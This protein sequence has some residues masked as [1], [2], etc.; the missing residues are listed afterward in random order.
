METTGLYIHVPFCSGKCFYC[1]FYSIPAQPV[2]IDDYLQ[3]LSREARILRERFF[4]D[5]RP[6]VETIYIGGGTPTSLDPDQLAILGRIIA[7][8]FE[9]TSECEFTSEAN[10]ESVTGEKIRVLRAAGVNRISLGV[11]TFDDS[12]LK[13]IGRR[14]TSR[15]AMAAVELASGA[16]VENISLDLIYALPGQTAEQFNRDLAKATGLPIRH[17]SC[18][19][20]TY[21]PGTTL[22]P[23]RPRELTLEQE[24]QQVDLFLTTHRTLT[25]KDFEHYEISNYAR[26][27][28]PCRHN[29]RYWKNLEY[30]GLGPS[31]AGL[32]NRRRYKNSTD[33]KTYCQRLLEQNELPVGG[34][35]T[36]SDLEFAGETAMLALRT[37]A[38]IDRNEFFR[39]T[40][41]EPFELYRAT[42]EK[43]KNSGLLETTEDRIFLNLRGF[44]LSNEVLAE[45]LK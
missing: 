14:H 6:R 36:L 21:E 10:P 43:F 9:R 5:R 23:S 40:G 35:E 28:F 32:L 33:L 38:G 31:G 24:D 2:L 30:L 41:Y 42:I 44:T 12:L 37:A 15:E 18:Y 45:F 34:E 29:V 8:N 22:Y 16:G 20:L 3:A 11:Q 19:E 25:A 39:R 17:L 27:G 26:P 1:D 13:T 7:E 4:E